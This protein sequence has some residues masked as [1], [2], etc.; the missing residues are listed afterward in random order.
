M[1][2]MRNLTHTAADKIALQV[3]CFYSCNITFS[4]LFAKFFVINFV[5]CHIVDILLIRFQKSTIEEISNSKAYS[6]SFIH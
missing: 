4:F 2:D 1:Q 6:Q 3:K 5:Y